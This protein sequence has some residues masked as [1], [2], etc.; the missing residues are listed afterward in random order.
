MEIVLIFFFRM[1]FRENEQIIVLLYAKAVAGF[2]V[3]MRCKN[4]FLLKNRYIDYAKRNAT[5]K[6]VLSIYGLAVT[7]LQH[8]Y[9]VRL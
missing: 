9:S 4:L 7:A 8:D 2:I 5:V 6:G 3:E 1:I